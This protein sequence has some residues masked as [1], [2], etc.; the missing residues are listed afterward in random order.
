MSKTPEQSTDNPVFQSNAITV[1]L[2]RAWF[3]VPRD[4]H[5]A[6]LGI[7]PYAH[8]IY[9]AVAEIEGVDAIY[10][11]ADN[12]Y[13]PHQG[14]NIIALKPDADIQAVKKS[15][16]A[17]ITRVTRP[18]YDDSPI[19]H[20]Y[21]GKARVST[22]V[23]QGSHGKFPFNGEVAPF[24]ATFLNNLR[25]GENPIGASGRLI[26]AF[27]DGLGNM[28]GNM[29]VIHQFVQTGADA[30]TE[31]AKGF[32]IIRGLIQL[33]GEMDDIRPRFHQATRNALGGLG[34]S[35]LERNTVLP[36]EGWPDR[37]PNGQ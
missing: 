18:T 14:L 24:A 21:A 23:V 16:E 7:P 8:G 3:D 36:V 20:F 2:P 35:K 27:D 13:Q 12:G 4:V 9:D 10:A 33:H 22:A 17:E 25:D 37:S 5:R 1:E 26:K 11:V 28:P 31:Q 30:E 19:H 6:P 34:Y 29:A 32:T 15:I